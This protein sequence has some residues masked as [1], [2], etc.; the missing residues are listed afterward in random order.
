MLIWEEKTYVKKDL[1]MPRNFAYNI[2]KKENKEI[3][4]LVLVINYKDVKLNMNNFN[5]TLVND[6]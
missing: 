4:S 1:M 6:L 5:T 3:I 2:Y